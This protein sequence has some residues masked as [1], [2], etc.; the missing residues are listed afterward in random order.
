MKDK[1]FGLFKRNKGAQAAEPKQEPVKEAPKPKAAAQE[2]GEMIYAPLEGEVK[3][4]ADVN[5]GVFSE[6]ML[7][8]GVAIE[9]SIGKVV[10]PFDGTV[11]MVYTTKHA[12]ALASDKGTEVLIHVGLDTVKL[13]GEHYEAKVENGQKVKAGDVLVEFDIPAIKAAGYPVI[14]PVI[15]TDMEAYKDIECVAG[16]TVKLKENLVIVKK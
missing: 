16:N 15:F 8:K 11:L 9:P 5:D 13:G 10:A 1:L 4:L 14:T 7:G 6:E 12:I 2:A 3:T